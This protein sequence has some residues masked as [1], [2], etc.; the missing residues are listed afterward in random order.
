MCLYTITL[1]TF[2]ILAFSWNFYIEI[3]LSLIQSVVIN[4]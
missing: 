1:V 3:L 2:L 4:D